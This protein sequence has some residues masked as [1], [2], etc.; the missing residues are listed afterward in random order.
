MSASCAFCALSNAFSG[1][2]G[3]TCVEISRLCATKAVAGLEAEDA[4]DALDAL[5]KVVSLWS[6]GQSMVV[7]PRMSSLGRLMSFLLIVVEASMA[8]LVVPAVAVVL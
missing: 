8:L 7:L 3:G 6:E 4:D 2:S 1:V 5:S